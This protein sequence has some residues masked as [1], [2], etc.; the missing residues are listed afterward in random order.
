MAAS[1]EKIEDVKTWCRV[2]LHRG[3]RPEELY[4]DI[5][6]Q[7]VSEE[8][9]PLVLGEA[10]GATTA[11]VD[12]DAIANCAVTK[13]VVGTKG[14]KQVATKKA[15]VFTWENFLTPEQ[16]E[17]T[18]SL[19]ET[20]LRPSTV[21]N[22]LG[23]KYVRT[24]TTCDLGDIMDPFVMELNDIISQ[25][26]G[27]HW[28]YAETTQ[29]QKYEVGQEFKAHTDFFEPE[30]NEFTPNTERM[31]QRTWTVMI[32]LNETPEGGATRFKRLDKLFRPK[33][34]MAVLWN[35]LNRDGTVNHFTL[36]HGMKPRKGEKY[37]ITKWF[38]EKG[39]GPMFVD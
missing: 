32:Y 14:L 25:G 4:P 29:G 18:I 21:T 13:R 20:S 28:S 31:G 3:I 35:N 24:S 26:L 39:W 6:K 11:P 33:Q 12:H 9:F 15:Q 38:R 7:G 37:I 2:N 27:I 1:P 17:R 36:H 5:L 19:M 8:E 10:F 34:G 30:T 23:D 22:D 16:C